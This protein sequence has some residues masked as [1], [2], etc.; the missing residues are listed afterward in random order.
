M[1]DVATILP[2]NASPAQRAIEQAIAARLAAIDPPID[3]L[4]NPQTCPLALLPWLAWAF[5]VEVWDSTW[6]EA[7]KRSVV[8]ASLDVHRRKGTRGALIQALAAVGHA[9]T[10]VEWWEETPRADPYTFRV[11]VDVG[12]GVDLAEL[13]LIAAQIEAAKNV[14]SH[15]TSLTLTS[16]HTAGV[17]VGGIGR[18]R[19]RRR[20]P[21]R[22]A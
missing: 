22:A 16:T 15:L 3:T 17:T 18:A 2:P 4:W 6:S 12:D 8:A 13:Q 5:A 1:S 9:T 20:I 10:V 7:K 19:V 14:R 11:A 21:A